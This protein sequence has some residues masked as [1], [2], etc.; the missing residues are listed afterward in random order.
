ML[1]QQVIDLLKIDVEGME[2][3]VL[4]GVKDAIERDRPHIFVEAMDV[5][6]AEV[7]RSLGVFGYSLGYRDHMYDQCENIILCERQ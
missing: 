2:V 5:N 1:G 4:T 6:S 7:V 3:H